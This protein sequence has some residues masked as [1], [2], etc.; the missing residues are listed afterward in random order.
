MFICACI[1]HTHSCCLYSCLSLARHRAGSWKVQLAEDLPSRSQSSNTNFLIPEGLPPRPDPAAWLLWFSQDPH[2]RQSVK[3]WPLPFPTPRME[4]GQGH[5]SLLFLD[6][7]GQG[8]LFWTC[9]THSLQQETHKVYS[10]R[11]PILSF[12]HQISPGVL[13]H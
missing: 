9:D 8:I 12:Q 6:N 3:A 2:G 13:W 10:H 7:C 1:P 4:E 5:S 11:G